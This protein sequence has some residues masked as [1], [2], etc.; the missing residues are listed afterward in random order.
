MVPE[1]ILEY[2]QQK[3]NHR[4]RYPKDCENL[5]REINKTSSSKISATTIS[6]IFNLRDDG[7][8]P[9]LRTL[10]LIAE[11]IGFENW[12]TAI[13]YAIEN[14]K[15]LKNHAFQFN[16]NTNSN[17]TIIDCNE[18]FAKFL[19]Y[20]KNEIVGNKIQEFLDKNT[21]G[22]LKEN[23]KIL[24]TGKRI[25]DDV[26]RYVR[27]DGKRIF[28]IRNLTPEIQNGVLQSIKVELNYLTT[29]DKSDTSHLLKNCIV[30]DIDFKILYTDIDPI[31]LGPDYI[32]KSFLDIFPGIIKTRF[33]ELFNL[34][35]SN[36]KRIT[37]TERYQIND[38]DIRWYR[39]SLDP[40]ASGI[41][42][43]A[44]HLF[45]SE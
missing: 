44:T 11:Y 18:D 4:I 2:I 25:S 45:N 6:R 43:I 26:G 16:Y 13:K 40:F 41:V 21:I 23:I 28:L 9:T 38:I 10:D 5:S 30:L 34:C 8:K 36:R 35:I 31:I 19:Q 22:S 15:H 1:I 27:K 37:F 42:V 32:N 33:F 3:F 29:E 7:S 20:P 24:Q 17:L 39:Y 12:E 14:S